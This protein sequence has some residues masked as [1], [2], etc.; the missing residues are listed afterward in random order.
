MVEPPKEYLAKLIGDKV[1][2][3]TIMSDNEKEKCGGC[4]KNC[5]SGTAQCAG[6]DNWWHPSCGGISK[7]MFAMIQETVKECGSHVWCCR[8]CKSINNDL[9]KSVFVLHAN[10]KK[11][12]GKVTTNTESIAANTESIGTISETL[13]VVKENA[14]Q[15]ADSIKN[16]ILA[17]MRDRQSRS[18]NVVI[19]GVPEPEGNLTSQDKQKKDK[20]TI[21]D[22]A[23][24]I[25]VKVEEK[26]IKF[27]FRPGDLRTSNKQRPIVAGFVDKAIRDKLVALSWKL[28]DNNKLDFQANIIP[29]LTVKQRDEEK[30]MREECDKLNEKM[31]PEES[32]N[33]IHKPV[34]QRGEKKIQKLKRNKEKEQQQQERK[35][36]RALSPESSSQSD[37][38][39]KAARN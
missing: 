25:G 12:E 39:D 10:Y 14:T 31:T 21:S 29:D 15:S 8:V 20:E 23:S 5:G 32:E 28:T 16:E 17:E 33:Y 30:E 1:G 13:R 4:G 37:Q 36:K 7:T 38:P 26:D 24:A 9:K 6:C 35:K 3:V 18:C 34:G 11:L 19:H 2:E 27:L 22:I